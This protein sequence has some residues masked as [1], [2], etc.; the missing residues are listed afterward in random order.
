MENLVINEKYLTAKNDPVVFLGQETKKGKEIFKLKVMI[1]GNQVEVPSTY[2]LFPYEEQKINAMTKSHFQAN[3]NGGSRKGTKESKP[4]LSHKIDE[5]L[6][7]N[8]LSIDAIAELLKDAPEAAGKNL[9]ANIH[10]RLVS[11]KRRGDTVTKMGDGLYK[12]VQKTSKT[13]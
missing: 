8:K 13:R 5:H 9:K 11:Y 10:A 6:L 2:K 4:K 7:R 12:V 3:G 1:S